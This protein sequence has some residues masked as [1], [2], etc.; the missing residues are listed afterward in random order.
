VSE[1]VFRPFGFS[2]DEYD[3]LLVLRDGV[4]P[5]LREPLIQWILDNV[6]ETPYSTTYLRADIANRLRAMTR[7]DLGQRANLSVR[8]SDLDDTLSELQDIE[9]LRLV[10]ALASLHGSNTMPDIADLLDLSSSRWRI[11]VVD[12]EWRLVERLPEGVIDAT[13]DTIARSG[14]AGKLLHRAFSAAYRIDPNAGEAYKMAV[15][16]V[17]T[18]AHPVIE[19][20]NMG[21]TL[22]TML[23]VMRNSKTSWTIPLDERADHTGNNA[24][25]LADMMQA[26]WDGQEDRHRDGEVTIDEART[27]FHAAATL[28]SWFSE[29]HVAQR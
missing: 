20:K 12:D 6:T 2:D 19:P 27:A 8:L 15:K 28:V 16:A 4:P 1:N 10:D 11:G 9:L 24:S 23:A 21:A 5:D 17:E 3:E 25:F 26:L 13:M 18:A 7:V 22:G 14:K 29:G